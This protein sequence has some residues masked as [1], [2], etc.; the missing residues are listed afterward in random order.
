MYSYIQDVTSIYPS[1]RDLEE[2]MKSEIWENVVY[3][4]I[5]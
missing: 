3:T 1:G 4:K 5:P 2:I